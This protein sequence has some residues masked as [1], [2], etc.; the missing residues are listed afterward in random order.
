MIITI[1]DVEHG[2]CA[3]V[4]ANTGARVLI[5]CGYNPTTNWRP[6]TYLK[7]RGISY[8]EELCVTNYDED[9]VDDLPNLLNTVQIGTLRRN[10]TVS[11]PQLRHLKKVDG[12]GR[13]I[14]CLAEMTSRYQSPVSLLSQP[15]WGDVSFSAYCNHYPSDFIDENNLSVAFFVHHAQVSILFPG[16]LEKVGW[17][18]L[19]QSSSF[20][21]ALRRVHVLVAS[22]HGR[23]NGRCDELFSMT[24]WRPQV[25]II[26]DDYKQY[27]TQET[28][29]WY[30]QR[31]SG[32]NFYG[33]SRH[34]FTTRRDGTIHINASGLSCSI[35]TNSRLTAVRRGNSLATL[36]G[37]R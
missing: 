1:F 25:V 4:E 24:G 28:V 7:A 19:L 14:D 15:N 22:H 30:R 16:D 9:H 21:A 23:V 17:K 8:L 12:I 33:S 31:A 26:S 35:D 13:G 20:V 32:I 2:G 36:L 37:S 11:E 5:D 10:Q 27:D 6:S 18:K 34:V 29:N 3:L